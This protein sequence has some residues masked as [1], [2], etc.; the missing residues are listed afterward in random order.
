MGLAVLLNLP[1]EPPAPVPKAR[2]RARTMAGWCLGALVSAAIGSMT[3]GIH[4]LGSAYNYRYIVA[5]G[6]AGM[7]GGAAF[8]L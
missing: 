4:L 3:I 7:F 5:I 8:L 6:F 1:C 2:G